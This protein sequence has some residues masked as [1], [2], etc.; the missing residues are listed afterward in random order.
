M[1]VGSTK[2][3]PC[4]FWTFTYFRSWTSP[5]SMP[6]H[7]EFI[8]PDEFWGFI[9][10]L[11]PIN[12]SYWVFNWTFTYYGTV[13]HPHHIGFDTHQP[14]HIGFKSQYGWVADQTQYDGHG[15][16]G[17]QGSVFKI[18]PKISLLRAWRRPGDKYHVLGTQYH[19]LAPDHVPGTWYLVPGTNCNV[20]TAI[21][22]VGA[23]G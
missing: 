17:F 16:W 7:I 6:H 8:W 11:I 14:H 9:L 10:S 21:F 12:L 2:R 15:G 5:T 18:A 4:T 13:H 23:S 22:I 3:R 20:P 1:F 19:E